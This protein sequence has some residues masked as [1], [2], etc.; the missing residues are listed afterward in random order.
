MGAA[1]GGE[2]GARADDLLADLL[3][4][5]AV[6]VADT[7]LS[8]WRA[9]GGQAERSAA[10]VVVSAD[11]M[12]ADDGE[13]DGIVCIG[14]DGDATCVCL[15]DAGRAVEGVAL[16]LTGHADRVCSVAAAGER[17]VS[18]S[19]D[20]TIRLWSRESGECT[21]V[22]GGRHPRLTPCSLMPAL[23]MYTLTTASVPSSSHSWQPCLGCAGL[24]DVCYSLALRGD[25][26]LSGE[27]SNC[28][29]AKAGAKA[30]LWT[31][32]GKGATIAATYAEHT[33]PIWVRHPLSPL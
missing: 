20:K 29:G 33:G 19:V 17:I 11:C 15:Y 13:G 2:D 18:G 7:W 12:V 27:G 28:K 21:A 14:A 5:A 3:G 24:D 32:S 6:A 30:R 8:P 10:E 9:A 31:L 16:R 25:E 22:L 23:A 1:D 4:P 26:L